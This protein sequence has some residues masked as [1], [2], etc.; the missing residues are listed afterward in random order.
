M[1]SQPYEG[2]LRADAA[3]PR[4]RVSWRRRSRGGPRRAP[5][6]LA[7]PGLALLFA[8]H[9]VA[10]PVGAW[11]AFTDWNGLSP[12]EWIG[13]DNFR[14][15]FGDRRRRAE[16]SGNTLELAACSSSSST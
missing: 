7:L 1:T 10:P 6:L 15:I 12:R 9:F 2:D 8:F 13:L 3:A 16:R 5:W 4:A 14:E 11:Y